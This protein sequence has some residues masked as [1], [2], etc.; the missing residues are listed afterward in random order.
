MEIT[1]PL[2][3]EKKKSAEMARLQLFSLTIKNKLGGKDK[4]RVVVEAWANTTL[5]LIPNPI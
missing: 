2:G 5:F 4:G 3:E 1:K